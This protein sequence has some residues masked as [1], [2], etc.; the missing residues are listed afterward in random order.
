MKKIR[1]VT[2]SEEPIGIIISRG[3]RAE[4]RPII[5]AYIWG[6]APEP[7]AEPTSKVA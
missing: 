7:D 3:D 6:P 2:E 4:Q 5:S 1:V